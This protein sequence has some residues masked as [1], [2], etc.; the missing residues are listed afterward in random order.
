MCLGYC[1]TEHCS[2]GKGGQRCN[3]DMGSYPSFTLFT[4]HYLVFVSHDPFPYLSVVVTCDKTSSSIFQTTT[5]YTL[6]QE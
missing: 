2:D 6:H 1:W 4:F 3:K 5:A